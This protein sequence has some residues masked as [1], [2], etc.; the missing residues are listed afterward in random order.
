MYP[1]SN[2]MTNYTYE[3]A[4]FKVWN[5]LASY[6]KKPVTLKCVVTTWLRTTELDLCSQDS[7]ISQGLRHYIHLN[8]FVKRGIFVKYWKVKFNEIKI[9]LKLRTLQVS[10]GNLKF[11][12]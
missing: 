10:N 9:P 12:A 2:Q 7:P 4:K 5:R 3:K 8:F 11:T 1:N 6:Q